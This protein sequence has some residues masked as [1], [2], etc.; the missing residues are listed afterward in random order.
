MELGRRRKEQEW[1][2]PVKLK[3]RSELARSAESP[4]KQTFRVRS[5]KGS[6]Q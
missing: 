1:R 4:K 6:G 2:G 3:E 5:T